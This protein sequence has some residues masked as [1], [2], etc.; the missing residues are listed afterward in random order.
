MNC[1]DRNSGRRWGSVARIPP[2]VKLDVHDTLTLD[3]RKCSLV[4]S[5]NV[6]KLFLSRFLCLALISS[7]HS[8]VMVFVVSRRGP[9]TARRCCRHGR[10]STAPPPW[11]RTLCQAYRRRLLSITSIIRAHRAVPPTDLTARRPSPPGGHNPWECL[12]RRHACL[13]LFGTWYLLVLIGL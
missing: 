11:P 8:R 2:R 10:W 6:C 13:F 12:G 4:I 9:D 3:F 7:N 5:I 1:L